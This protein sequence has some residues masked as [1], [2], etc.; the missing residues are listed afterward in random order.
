M[1]PDKIKKKISEIGT[2][3]N[4]NKLESTNI[5][6]GF[7]ALK[8]TEGFSEFKYLKRSGYSFQLVLSSMIYAVT[9]GSKTAVSSLPLLREKGLAMGKDVLYRLKNN[10]GINWRKLLWQTACKFIGITGQEKEV[11]CKVRCLIFD[12]IL[13]EKTGKKMEKIGKVY[14]HV[15]NTFKLGY[16]MLL[17]L[18]WDG[19]SM[20][21]LD[22][23]LSREKGKRVEKPYGMSRKKLNSQ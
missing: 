3:F 22:F 23:S 10:E 12:D 17:G 14:D 20:I 11:S 5:L 8:L 4:E 15:T 9:S 18:Y 21:P 1:L 13:L 7:K 2:D 6:K 16:K 19:K